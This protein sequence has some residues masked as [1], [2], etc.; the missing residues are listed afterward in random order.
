MD[1]NTFVEMINGQEKL[2]F[3]D[4]KRM[5]I[6]ASKETD[7]KKKKE[8]LDKIVLGTLYYPLSRIDEL[9]RIQS[10]SFD[11]DDLANSFCE[12]WIKQIYNGTIE[13][14]TSFSHLIGP[15]FRNSIF[16]NTY[17]EREDT[18]LSTIPLELFEKLLIKYIQLRNNEIDVKKIDYNELLE[19]YF[20]ATK[21]EFIP[22]E[23][24]DA[25]ENI[26][27]SLLDEETNIVDIKPTKI[28]DYLKFYLENGINKELREETI[29]GTQ[30][31]FTDRYLDYTNIKEII[32]TYCTEREREFLYLFYG[33]DGNPHTYGEIAELYDISRNRV[34]QILA[35]GERKI[36]TSVS[37]QNSMDK[38][39]LDPT[40]EHGRSK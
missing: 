21:H 12:E 36:R 15:K 28:K 33:I 27:N 26:Y 2:S 30:A 20:P 17:G 8:M 14:K 4:A 19:I 39:I 32:D 23:V 37:S 11:K 25:L 22:D 38:D 13:N 24:L 18:T 34:R 9:E 31:I 16:T 35:K 5:Y 7:E 40:I 1:Y 10:A 3:S 6:E 29:Q